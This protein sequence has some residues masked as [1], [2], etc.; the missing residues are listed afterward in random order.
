MQALLALFIAYTSLASNVQ[1]PSF[2][3]GDG[4][5]TFTAHSTC[6]DTPMFRHAAGAT[7]C[8][9]DPDSGT[10]E[11]VLF[12]NGLPDHWFDPDFAGAAPQE[13]EPA[14]PLRPSPDFAQASL[15][16]FSS[17]GASPALSAGALVGFAVNGV[18]FLKALHPSIISSSST[19]TGAAAEADGCLGSVDPS[20]GAYHY[21]TA[22]PCLVSA[23]RNPASDGAREFGGR[24]A[25]PHGSLLHNGHGHEHEALDRGESVKCVGGGLLKGW[26]MKEGH[27]VV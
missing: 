21:T 6:P 3:Y 15:D 19:A 10:T 23:Q 16:R 24:R 20:S 5:S 7:E 8:L 1:D 26:C 11:L 14:F 27:H 2:V 25:A 18:P 12:S 13:W 22:P 4:V 9:F 17:G